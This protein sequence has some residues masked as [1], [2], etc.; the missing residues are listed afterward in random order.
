ML[1]PIP[2]NQD[3]RLATIRRYDLGSATHR[4]AFDGLVELAA[5]ITQCPIALVSIVREQDQ[6]FESAL[7]LDLE[8]TNLQSS[9]CSHAILGEEILEIG[10]TRL[11]IRTRDN[12]LVT[13]PADPKLFYAGAPIRTSY[14]IPLGSLCVL[15]RRPR[16]LG[17]AERSGLRILADQVMHRLELHEALRNEDAMR[18]EVDHRVK[19]SLANVAAMTRMA[20]RRASPEARDALASVERRIEVM[21]ALHEDLYRADNPDAPIDVSDYLERISRHLHTIAP[22]GVTLDCQFQPV[23]MIA[24]RASALG[25]LVNEMISNAC[26]HGFP[27]GRGGRV[28]V[29]GRRASITRY[30][31]TCID[32]GVGGEADRAAQATGPKGLGT[33]IMEAS[34]A[35]LDGTLEAGPTAGGY[36]VCLE[37]PIP[38][39]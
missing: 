23:R 2:P 8:S 20:A 11:D 37:F 17:D 25:V 12:P 36:R 32:D 10:D 34:A 9:I 13:D 21:V 33:R 3:V 26:K 7:G 14:G 4:G 24:R 31:I 19:N 22:S 5:Q 1:A 39:G 18:R 35:Q 15:D 28:T 29:V 6:K 38:Y 27:E 16:R 30:A